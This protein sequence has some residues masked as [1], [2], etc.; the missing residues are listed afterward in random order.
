MRFWGLK[1]KKWDFRTNLQAIIIY[2]NNSYLNTCISSILEWLN[3]F[4]LSIFLRDT[5]TSL[6][7][8][9]WNPITKIFLEQAIYKQFIH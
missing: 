1:M 4:F 6:K 8:P 7:I 5:A 2:I 3:I 9:V